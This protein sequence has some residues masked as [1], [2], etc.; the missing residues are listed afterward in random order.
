MI[1]DTKIDN[2][3]LLAGIQTKE[4]S[5]KNAD[6]FKAEMLDLF[7]KGHRNI[8]LSFKQV[9]YIDSSFL[10]ALVASLKSGLSKKGDI[11][12]V[13]LKQDIHDL[14]CLI[15]MDKVF[16]IYSTKDEAFEK[17]LP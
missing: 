7:N 4:A 14:L 16:R 11:L 8:V 15:R 17:L 9:E 13:E 3:I 2:G 10:G 1:L 12:L 5:L 6:E